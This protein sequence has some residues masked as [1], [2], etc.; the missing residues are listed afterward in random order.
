M[1]KKALL[2]IGIIVVP[3]LGIA[4]AQQNFSCSMGE[5]TRRV[6]IV[7]EPGVAVPC[8]VHYYKDDEAPGER[9]V[10]WSAE[11]DAGYCEARTQEFVARLS[12][13]GWDCGQPIVAPAEEPVDDEEIELDDTADLA[14]AP[15]EDPR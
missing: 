1:S 14:P 5:L 10:L 7:S 4:Q 11:N 8:E 9:Q 13:M 3:A 15:V 12:A 6:E 2:A